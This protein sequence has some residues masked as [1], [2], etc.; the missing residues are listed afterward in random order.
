MAWG[1]QDEQQVL[2]A[3]SSQACQRML[4]CDDYTQSWFTCMM[5]ACATAWDLS[6]CSDAV[7]LTPASIASSSQWMSVVLC[8]FVCFSQIQWCVL[9]TLCVTKQVKVMTI[10][11][12]TGSQCDDC[13]MSH[14]P[15][16]THLLEEHRLL[17]ALYDWA[18][19][20]AL[21]CCHP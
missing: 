8:R 2:Q 6:S 1:L 20:L 3:G 11:T 19:A 10:K 7:L 18:A 16:M 4:Q 21:R 13:L 17:R 14:E 12:G 5:C 15:W 9:F